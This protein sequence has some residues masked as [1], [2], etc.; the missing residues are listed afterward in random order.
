VGSVEQ[1]SVRLVGRRSPSA[2][3]TGSS[4]GLSIDVSLRE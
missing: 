3:S 2:I 4:T 1:D